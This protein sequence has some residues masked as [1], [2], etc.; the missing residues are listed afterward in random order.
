MTKLLFLLVSGVSLLAEMPT[1]LAIRNARVVT[2]SGPEITRGTVAVRNGLIE[3]EGDSVSIPQDAWIVD[4]EGLI[5]YPALIGG[6]STLGLPDMAP[7][8]LTYGGPPRQ[9]TS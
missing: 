8:P 3:A 7:A 5:L 6:V 9:R 2:V 1:V 4:G